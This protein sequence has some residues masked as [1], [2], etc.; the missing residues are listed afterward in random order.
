MTITQ[1]GAA[2][3]VSI[4]L[5]LSACQLRP[6]SAEGQ[7]P[8]ANPSNAAPGACGSASPSPSLSAASA[9]TTPP[10]APTDAD[11]TRWSHDAIDA[12]DRGDAS[13]LAAVLSVG[14][15]QFEG[16]SP[17]T[18]DQEIAL[19]TNRK[20]GA[21]HIAQRVWASEQVS[22]HEPYALFIGEAKE[23]A[24]GNDT[25][26]GSDYDGWYT[27]VWSREGGAY[28]LAFWS[29]KAAGTEA[30][31]DRWNA[32]FRG[33]GTGFSKEPNHLLVE[34]V[35]KLRPGTALDV[36]M[37][38]G[39]NAL[40]LAS[41]GWKVT[42]VDFADEGVRLARE[43]AAARHLSLDAVN[44][45]LDKYDFGTNKW[46]LVTFLYVPKHPGWVE[47]AQRGVKRGG[48]F[49]LEFFHR[50]D[51]D[52][53]DQGYATGELEALFKDGWE[54]VRDEVVDTT[55]DWGSDHETML[56]F[57]AKKR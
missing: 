45:D 43:A 27:L 19:V 6:M 29:W 18:R 32:A 49:V 23:H 35:S 12:F 14:F 13:A 8:P 41:R 55:P 51:A 17:F 50:G 11:V 34:T 4:A 26:G 38:Q 20:P 33:E 9:A 15:L 53:A 21:P 40:Y 30:Q 10:A 37:G 52:A 22:L 46:D 56:R 3:S 54:L 16:D 48:L 42:G 31:R 44:A 25:H 39:R 57:V 5:L 1:A 2:L 47:R 7:A 28:K 24:A 36:A